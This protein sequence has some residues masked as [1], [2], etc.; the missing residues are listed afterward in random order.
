MATFPSSESMPEIL[1]HDNNCKL[2][3]HLEA[4]NNQYFK[5][6][7]LPVDVFHFHA[8][9]KIS[10]ISCQRYC[11][12]AAFPDLI[13]DGKWRVNS[14]IC[15]KTNAWFGRFL[16]IVREMEATRYGFFLNEMIKRRNRHTFEKLK[17]EV[18]RY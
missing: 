7:G 17:Q 2:R 12:P 9:H 4:T 5:D 16:P 11:N 14:S 13:R 18:G 3:L 15:E 10:D 6:T 8:K 1:I